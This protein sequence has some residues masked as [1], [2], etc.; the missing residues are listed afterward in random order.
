MQNVQ[1][2]PRGLAERGLI[3]GLVFLA[4][5][6]LG[7]SFARAAEI[8]PSIGVSAGSHGGDPQ[9]STG[10][11]LRSTV[12]PFVKGELGVAY[13]R[14]S[15]SMSGSTLNST[16][17]PVTAS[18]WFAPVP[19]VY[20]GGGAGWYHSTVSLAGAPVVASVTEQAFGT[21]VGGG[22]RMPVA[23][24][25]ALDLNARYVV[26]QKRTNS[27]TSATYDPSFWTAALGLA[28]KF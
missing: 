26:L 25:I 12:I 6:F 16:T 17:W 7:V 13:H 24:L 27:L 5:L 28:V 10:L 18:V 11:A 8:V 14:D 9:F 20:A 22:L 21:H 15:Y 4:L 3:G 19:F 1:S 2:K 23:P